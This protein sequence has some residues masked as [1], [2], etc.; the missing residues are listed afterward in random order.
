MN[1]YEILATESS[2]SNEKRVVAKLAIDN[3]NS[4]I[5]S[6]PKPNLETGVLTQTQVAACLMHQPDLRTVFMSSQDQLRFSAI[7]AE[8]R[9]KILAE[10]KKNILSDIIVET[11][12]NSQPLSD[13][14]CIDPAGN[15]IDDPAF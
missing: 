15:P 6:I 5:H 13:M 8:A 12:R 2:K 1:L 4:F 3:W 11:C 9:A 7:V 14:V 10:F